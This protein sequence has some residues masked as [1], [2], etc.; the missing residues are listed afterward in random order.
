MPICLIYWVKEIY[1]FEV[2][3]NGVLRLRKVH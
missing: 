3:D 1:L 2:I